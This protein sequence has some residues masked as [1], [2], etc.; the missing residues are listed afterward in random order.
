MNA[1]YPNQGGEIVTPDDLLK[2]YE[3]DYGAFIGRAKALA[4]QEGVYLLMVIFRANENGVTL[5]RASRLG[6]SSAVDSFGRMLSIMDDASADQRVMETQVTASGVRTI[7][8]TIGDALT[9]LCTA[10]LIGMI[11]RGILG[12]SLITGQRLVRV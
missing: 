12:Q 7:Y 11:V 5:V 10:G 9:W 3:P 2:V 6:L 4:R 1:F 8:A